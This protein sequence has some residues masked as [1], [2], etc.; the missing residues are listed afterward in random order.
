MYDILQSESEV[1]Q[2][3]NQSKGEDKEEEE[4][5]GDQIVS[6]VPIAPI[7]KEVIERKT[8]EIYCDSEENLSQD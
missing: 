4:E 1:V 7:H 2:G 6:I 3:K 5:E 8:I